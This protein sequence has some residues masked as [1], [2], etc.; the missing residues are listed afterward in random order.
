M[1]RRQPQPLL[2]G[3]EN[4]AT[5]TRPSRGLCTPHAGGP[6]SQGH[7]RSLHQEVRGRPEPHPQRLAAQ[8]QPLPRQSLPGP[9]V[10]RRS[11]LASW[12]AGQAARQAARQAAYTVDPVPPCGSGPGSRPH[13]TA[14]SCHRR[15][16]HRVGLEAGSVP[17]RGPRMGAARRAGGHREAQGQRVRALWALWLHGLLPGPGASAH[18]TRRDGDENSNSEGSRTGRAESPLPPLGHRGAPGAQPPLFVFEHS[19]GRAGELGREASVH[20]LAHS[21]PQRAAACLPGPGRGPEARLALR[22]RREALHVH[23]PLLLP[24]PESGSAQGPRKQAVSFHRE[25]RRGRRAGRGCSHQPGVH[26]G[27]S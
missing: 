6:P 2:E 17:S 11:W 14:H 22:G 4:L 18:P 19:P 12:R 16:N 13:S 27:A 1:P 25:Q 7:S 5:W 26:I 9:L 23:G 10:L 21:S 3:Q 24:L 15:P 8:R 20:V